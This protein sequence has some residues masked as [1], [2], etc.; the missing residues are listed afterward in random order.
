MV[1]SVKMLSSGW[2][3]DVVSVGYPGPVV[4][5]R[6]MA[7]PHNLGKGWMG[8]DFA[9]AFKLPA[10]VVNDAAMQALGSYQGRQNVVPLVLGPGSA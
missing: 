4:H 8:F 9:A 3:Y 7:E 6:P 5:D 2:K 1:S 10:K